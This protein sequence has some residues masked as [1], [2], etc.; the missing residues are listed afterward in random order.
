MADRHLTTAGRIRPAVAQVEEEQMLLMQ[1]SMPEELMSRLAYEAANERITCADG[2]CR[3]EDGCRTG[4]AEGHGSSPSKLPL[5]GRKRDSETEWTPWN[6]PPPPYRRN[7]RFDDP[8]DTWSNRGVRRNGGAKRQY[9]QSNGDGF[10]EDTAVDDGRKPAGPPTDAGLGREAFGEIVF[11]SPGDLAQGLGRQRVENPFAAS[12]RAAVDCRQPAVL[13]AHVEGPQRLNSRRDA[14]AHQL[15]DR[16]LAGREAGTKGEQGSGTLTPREEV[17]P[18][19]DN[20][21]P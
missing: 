17:R 5:A 9:G 19:L 11:A 8:T 1:R 6:G 7:P 14:V 16:Y 18:L 4:M 12:L 21:K 20:T 15:L 13:S 10:I 3:L 2:S